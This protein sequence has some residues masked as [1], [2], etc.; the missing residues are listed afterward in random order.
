M[1]VLV[2]HG[3]NLNLLGERE[4]QIYGN[5][6]LKQIN[7]ILH[8]VAL[9]N[10]VKIRFFQSNHEGEIIDCIHLNRK[11]V[12]GILI[13]PAAFTHY[14]IAIRD[15]ILAVQLPVVEVHLSDILE[16]EKFRR[17]NVISDVTIQQFWGEKEKSY[18]KG[19]LYLIKNLKYRGAK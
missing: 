2:I 10:K 4:P 15:A 12:N 9:K 16:R 5:L 19:L 1:E 11:K 14:S 18:V 6:T 7:K 17:K 3:P 13:N 8:G